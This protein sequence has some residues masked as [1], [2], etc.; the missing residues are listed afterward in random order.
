MAGGR[1]DPTLPT[2]TAVDSPSPTPFPLDSSSGPWGGG[3][4]D[5]TV[6]QAAGVRGV[7]EVCSV[8][9]L[10]P[11]EGTAWGRGQVQVGETPYVPQAMPSRP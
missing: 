2:P 10:L 7:R 3:Q 6:T 8:R 5:Q 11:S 1:G 9:V 4:T